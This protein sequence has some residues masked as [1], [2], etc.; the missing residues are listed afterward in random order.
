MEV[1]V[2]LRFNRDLWDKG[3]VDNAIKEA[4]PDKVAIK[5]AAIICNSIEL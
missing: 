2:M 3:F 5:E 1:L 4:E